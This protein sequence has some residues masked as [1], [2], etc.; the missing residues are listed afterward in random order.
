VKKTSGEEVFNVELD[1]RVDIATVKK[2]SHKSEGG[3]EAG[4]KEDRRHPVGYSWTMKGTS[5]KEEGGNVT[6][7]KSDN[8]REN[9]G[10][11]SEGKF[12]PKSN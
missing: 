12:T 4:G 9:S 8:R 10:K 7:E 11:K 6:N 1:K 2:K 5:G 3:A